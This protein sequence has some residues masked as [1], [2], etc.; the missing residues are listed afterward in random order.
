M[1]FHNN[2]LNFTLITLVLASLVAIARHYI[3]MSKV[4][5]GVSSCENDQFYRY[6]R[7]QIEIVHE[8]K[9][10]GQS[11]IINIDQI[12][13]QLHTDKEDLTKFIQTSLATTKIVNDTIRGIISVEDMEVVVKKYTVKYILCKKCG[14]PELKDERCNSCGQNITEKVEKKGNSRSEPVGRSS[15]VSKVEAEEDTYEQVPIKGKIFCLDN[16]NGKLIGVKNAKVTKAEVT[17]DEV[18]KKLE[19]T[20]I[21]APSDEDK[22]HYDN[23]NK[24]MEK[25]CKL[26]NQLYN[27]RDHILESGNKDVTDLDT[28]INKCWNYDTLPT[29]YDGMSK[30]HLDQL[31][32]EAIELEEKYT[33]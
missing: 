16:Y 17:N 5:I 24:L 7:D 31:K 28:L 29:T 18:K 4:N 32:K 12:C 21:V 19:H 15:S 6:K 30:E 3:P 25:Y 8:S 33:K 9:Y 11:K 13:S 23:Y 20:P 22:K 14:L 10:G 27:F 26:L 1:I 2:T